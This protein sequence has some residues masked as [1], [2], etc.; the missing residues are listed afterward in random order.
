MGLF[1]KIKKVAKRSV[2][3]VATGGLSEVARATGNK[4]FAGTLTSIFAP[5]SIEDIQLSTALAAP[6]VGATL[7][8][9]AGFAIGSTFAQ[10]QMA[11]QQGVQNPEVSQVGIS[12]FLGGLNRSL[13]NLSGF[14]GQIGAGAQLGS[15]VLSGFLPAQGPTIQQQSPVMMTS[16]APTIQA[17]AMAG[18]AP[19]VLSAMRAGIQSILAKLSANIGKSVSFRAAMILIRKLGTFAQSP[20]AIGAM[21]GL[22]AQ[23]VATLLI[24]DSLKKRRRMN[25]GNIKALRRAHRRIEGFHRI[26]GTNDKLRS[27][28]RRRAPSKTIVVSGKRCD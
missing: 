24:A 3:A 6:V 9:P 17:G 4:E 25:P 21:V 27:P 20:A 12:N 11:A 26:C 14:G 1:K 2:T 19:A 7:G 10:S 22:T 18:A 8:G 16:V 5:S 13:E 15:A 23:E 28:R